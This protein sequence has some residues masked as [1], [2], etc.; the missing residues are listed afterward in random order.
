MKRP[1]IMLKKAFLGALFLFS[2]GS[3]Y[4]QNK[5]QY[6]SG[7]FLNPIGLPIF[8]AGNFGECR[9]GHFHSGI[10]I[11]TLGEENHE[12]HAAA[13]G[14]IARIKMEKGGFGHA[15]YIMHPNGYTTLYAHLNNFSPALQKYL[16]EKQ[17]EQKRWD[18]DLSLSPTQFP[19]AKGDLIAFSGNTGAS[20][21]PHLH[22]EVRNT[23]TEHPLNP[24][25]FHFEMKDTIP[26][27]PME[28]AVYTGSVYNN[29][30]ALPDFVPLKL[31]GDAYKPASVK[32]DV[33]QLTSDTLVITSENPVGFGVNVDDYMN[34]SDN[35]LAPLT[36]SLMIDGKT[37]SGIFLDDIGY[38][39]TRYINAFADY[40]AHRL[41]GKWYQL[42][43]QLP[44]NK[45]DGIYNNLNQ[46]KGRIEM[47]DN[48]THKMEISII[49]NSGNKS[50]IATYIKLLKSPSPPS[51]SADKV[52]NIGRAHYF[53]DAGIKFTL[54]E[55]ALYEDLA[56]NYECFKGKHEYSHEYRLHYPFVPLHSYSELQIKAEK[57]IPEDLKNKVIVQCFDGKSTS[58]SAVTS[59]G[60]GWYKTKFR[61]FGNYWLDVDTKGP[62][63][64]SK[65]KQGVRMS[66]AEKIVFTVTDDKTSVKSFSGF[67]DDKWVCFEQH[68]SSFFYEFD[69][70][71]TTGKHKLLFKA[72]DESGNASQVSLNFVR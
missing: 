72:I 63:I 66:K 31:A 67:I 39:V 48:R 7:Y 53:E 59:S 42:L 13:E 11:K 6:P 33:V 28:L 68:G 57:A 25:L 62:K 29:G 70:H 17:Y 3:T 5:V 45:L 38:D 56:F 46:N 8:L 40:K 43:F 58:G 2:I 20:T 64:A 10:D 23:K 50:Q 41:T 22:F 16:R 30:K 19:V 14:Y 71:C 37:Q 32:G 27:K 55:K 9:P 24:M 52:F 35:T 54:D 26:A 60:N 61:E 65:Y 47:F 69:S 15:L 44:G 1:F 34:G 4:A 18:L 12:V 51:V 21:A 36:M 49:D